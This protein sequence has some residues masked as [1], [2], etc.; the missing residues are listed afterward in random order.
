[1]RLKFPK[2]LHFSY[3]GFVNPKDISESLA[4]SLPDLYSFAFSLLPEELQARQLVIDAVSAFFLREKNKFQRYLTKNREMQHFRSPKASTNLGQQPG[5]QID[6][7]D[8]FIHQLKI[9]LYSLVYQIAQKR[10]EHFGSY[11]QNNQNENY[12]MSAAF[13]R[14]TMTKRALTY[15]KFKTDFE[16]DEMGEILKLDRLSVISQLNLGQDELFFN[17]GIENPTYF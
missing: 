12:H 1:M 15:L 9:V 10:S 7:P 3:N 11:F 5:T 4:T 16:L 2:R 17:L 13:F 6:H 14:L 8:E